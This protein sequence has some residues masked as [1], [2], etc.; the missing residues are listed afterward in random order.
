[1]TCWPAQQREARLD[2]R[3]LGACRLDIGELRARQ[4]VLEHVPPRAGA[5]KAEDYGMQVA[6][7][8]VKKLP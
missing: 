4:P 5:T 3:R 2:S 8:V 1:L 6:K 7:E